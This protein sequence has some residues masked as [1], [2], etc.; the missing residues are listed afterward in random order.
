MGNMGFMDKVFAN[1][2]ARMDAKAEATQAEE[3]RK[4]MVEQAQAEVEAHVAEKEAEYDMR[5]V[6]V[7]TQVVLKEKLW[8]QESKN[9]TD[10]D[11]A[12]RYYTVRGYKL[13]SSTV[14]VVG[15]SHLGAGGDRQVMTLIFQLVDAF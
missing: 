13:I 1:A 9:M 6:Y 11:S 10:L 14:G 7:T 8:G 12:L 15:G 5:P 2:Q 4:A 3:E